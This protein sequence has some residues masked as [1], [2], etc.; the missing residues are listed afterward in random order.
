M[1]H[2]PET[3]SLG[4]KKATVPE[5]VLSLVEKFADEI[6][7]VLP[8]STIYLFGSHAKGTA[9]RHS[10]ID[11]AVMVD[12]VKGASEDYRVIEQPYFAINELSSKHH[13]IEGH[14]VQRLHNKSGFVGVI[15]KTGIY[16]R[17][18]RSD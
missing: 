15:L 14:L 12:E 2:T 18:P 1:A 11:V 9:H 16:I 8:Y 6:Q 7:E 13:P 5:D 17:G 10:D 4:S 3:S